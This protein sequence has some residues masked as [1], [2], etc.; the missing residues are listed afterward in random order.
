MKRVKVVALALTFTFVLLAFTAQPV[1]AASRYDSLRSYMT[2]RYDAV[3]GGY[4]IPGEG[5][6]RINPTYGA[7]SIMNAVGTL[8]NRPAPVTI[9]D[10]MDFLVSHQMTSGEEDDPDNVRYGGLSDYLLG[11]VSNGINYRG[12]VLWHHLKDQSDIPGTGDYDINATANLLW[13]NRTYTESGGYASTAEI[14][15][16]GGD[17]DLLST[18]YALASFRILDDLYPL[19]NALDWIF[20][21]TATV[22]WIENC[23]VGGAYKLSPDSTLPS[24]TATYAAVLAYTALYPAITVPD[25]SNLHAWL[26]DRQVLDDDELEF[27]GGF[28]EGNGTEVPSLLSTYFALSAMN[29]LDTITTANSTA[30]EAFVLNCQTPEGSFA[31]APG[32]STGS[33][34]YSGY[35]CQILDFL[36]DGAMSS[37]SSQD[38]FSPGDTGFEWRTYVIIGI[39]VIVVVLAVLGVRAD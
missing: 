13:I 4:S 27:I 24:V 33:L 28:E 17:P 21:E 3:R 14:A 15:S 9:V 39:L 6:V 30:A 22:D 19:E 18:A 35:A 11:P 2:S 8:D 32:Y 10:V 12:L 25:S 31:N 7:I 20:N 16:E 5:V 1:A 26:L 29:M 36:F 37:L 38:P 23:K 34:L